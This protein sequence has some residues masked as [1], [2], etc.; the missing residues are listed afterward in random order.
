MSAH[1]DFKGIGITMGVQPGG[2]T[3]FWVAQMIAGTP[4]VVM[5]LNAVLAGAIA[6][7]AVL[8]IGA[9]PTTFL[10]VG[11]ISFVIMIVAQGWYASRSIGKIEDAHRSLFPSPEANSPTR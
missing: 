5:I 2:G 10:L 4:T 1:D 7:I 11:A 9:A 6:A 8:R 3:V